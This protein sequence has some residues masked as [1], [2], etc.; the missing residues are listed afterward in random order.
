MKK[1]L[2]VVVISLVVFIAAAQ[3]PQKVCDCSPLADRIS[4]LERQAKI[5]NEGLTTEYGLT[6]N[7]EAQVQQ[8]RELKAQVEMCCPSEK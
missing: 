2:A 4:R 3:N 8:F 7:E 1:L 6:D 5:W